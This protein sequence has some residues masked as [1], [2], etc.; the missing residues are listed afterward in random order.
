MKRGKPNPVDIQV[1]HNNRLA[2]HLAKK[3]FQKMRK[4]PR[5]NGLVKLG[6][7]SQREICFETQCIADVTRTRGSRDTNWEPYSHLEEGIG[8]VFGPSRP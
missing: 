3:Q 7:V 4:N 2:E 1:A 6:W 5:E 8:N